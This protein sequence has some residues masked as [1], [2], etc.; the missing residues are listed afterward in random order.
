MKK[1]KIGPFTIIVQ[2]PFVVHP[3][4]TVKIEIIANP[5]QCL[6]YKEAII[7]SISESD[8]KKPQQIN[9]YLTGCEPKIDLENFDN[10]FQ[11][12]SIANDLHSVNKNVCFFIIDIFKML[13]NNNY[14]YFMIRLKRIQLLSNLKVNCISNRLVLIVRKR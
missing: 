6:D 12:V 1:L 2:S 5:K 14:Y 13:N 11:S 3:G 7:V 9:F 10:I 8:R 4:E